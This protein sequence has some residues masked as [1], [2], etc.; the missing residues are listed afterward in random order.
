MRPPV[1]VTD[2][3]VTDAFAAAVGVLAARVDAVGPVA[4]FVGTD[5][6]ALG[7]AVLTRIDP[8]VSVPRRVATM[9]AAPEPVDPLRGIMAFPVLPE[10]TY[11]Y[12]DELGGGWML[13]GADGLEPDT[14]ILL[15]TNPAFTSAFLV[16]M[17]HEMDGELLWRSYPTDQRGTPFQRF[18]ERVDGTVDIDPVHLWPSDQPLATAGQPSRFTTSSGAGADGQIVLL[19]RGQL[20]RRYPNMVVYAVR[21]SHAAPGTQVDPAGQP[22][23]AGRLQPDVSLV[24]FGL[25]PQQ[26]ASDEWWFILEQQLTAPRF[27]FDIGDAPAAEHVTVAALG[28]AVA[29]ADQVAAQLLQL[30]I[31]VA[32]HRDRLL[33]PGTASP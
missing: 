7:N 3:V 26:L 24:G 12:L 25:T 28:A 2:P 31:R 1:E 11:R 4:A 13:P 30:P 18:W 6:G 19:L 5:P 16:G 22:V 10:A 14:A 27:G 21:G 33:L 9:I 23:F 17:N 15:Q 29:T 8:T 20:L 32:I